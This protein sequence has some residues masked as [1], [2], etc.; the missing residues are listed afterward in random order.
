VECHQDAGFEALLDW[1]EAQDYLYW[2]TFN[3][4]PTHLFLPRESVA[5]GETLRRLARWKALRDTSFAD[6]LREA[7]REAEAAKVDFADRIASGQSALATREAELEAAQDALA[8]ARAALEAG[9]AERMRLN[10]L[11]ATERGAARNAAQAAERRLGELRSDLGRA[12]SEILKLEKYGREL[13]QRHLDTLQS[14]AWRATAPA[15]ALLQKL[16]R[17]PARPPF[18]PRLLT[19]KISAAEPTPPPPPPTPTPPPPP[20]GPGRRAPNR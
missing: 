13:E 17:R 18:K 19:R 12:R 1:A 5:E 11:L 10:V 14:E 2:E 3:S 16:R 9:M 6:R 7:R 4:T 15:R 8:E 20:G